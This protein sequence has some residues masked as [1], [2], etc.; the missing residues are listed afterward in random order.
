MSS[1]GFKVQNKDGFVFALLTIFSVSNED[2]KLQ[3]NFMFTSLPALIKKQSNFPDIYKEFQKG[4][5]AKSYMT[6]RLLIY[7]MI[8]YLRVSSYIRKPF[9]IYDFTS[10]PI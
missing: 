9:L 7:C 2:I 5:V 3:I 1:V 10:D 8:K 6:N 4:S